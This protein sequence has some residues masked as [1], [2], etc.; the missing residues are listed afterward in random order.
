LICE[1]AVAALTFNSDPALILRMNIMTIADFD[2][3][4]AAL[5]ERNGV[6]AAEVWASLYRP[7][8]CKWCRARYTPHAEVSFQFLY[9]PHWYLHGLEESC[10]ACWLGVGPFAVDVSAPRLN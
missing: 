6:S 9:R 1:W 3:L 4:V 2:A 7:R 10:M 8:V 5:A